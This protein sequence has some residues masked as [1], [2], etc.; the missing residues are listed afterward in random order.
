MEENKWWATCCSANGIV[1]VSW[2]VQVVMKAI[3]YVVMRYIM[4]EKASSPSQERPV[5]RRD[6][7]SEERPLPFT[8]VGD[9][10][11][12]VVQICEHHNPVV[13]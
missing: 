11:V 8:K 10:R 9:G 6:G 4:Q 13:R 12:G 3:T 7:T 2:M 5:D 1:L